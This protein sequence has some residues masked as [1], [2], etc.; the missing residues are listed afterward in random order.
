MGKVLTFHL[1]EATPLCVDVTK[2][3]RVTFDVIGRCLKTH[4]H[5]V[6]S[7]IA[8]IERATKPYLPDLSV[9]MKRN[10]LRVA[11]FQFVLNRT[12]G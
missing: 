1:N 12:T 3:T 8:H 2:G 11:E 7:K 6:C 10:A 9:T 4:I 5:Q